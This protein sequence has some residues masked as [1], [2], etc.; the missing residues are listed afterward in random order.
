MSQNLSRPVQIVPLLL[1]LSLTFYSREIGSEALQYIDG[2]PFAKV[3]TFSTYEEARSWF[4]GQYLG[5]HV[6]TVDL[7]E[8][9]TAQANAM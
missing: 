4:H 6:F 2:V 7:E 5:G 9:N 1:I 8:Y 3:Q